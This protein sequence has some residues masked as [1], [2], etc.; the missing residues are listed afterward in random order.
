[1]IFYLGTHEPAWLTRTTV[2]LFVSR[3]RLARRKSLPRAVGRWALDSGGFTEL[4]MYGKWQTEPGRYAD[5][6]QA[7]RESIGGLDFAAVQDWMCEPFMLARTGKTVAEHQALTIASYLDLLALAPSVP[8]CPVLQ[9]Y[10]IDEYLHHVEQY[11][12]AGINLA[13][14]PRVGVGSVCR[15]Q[16]SFEAVE[17]F[18]ALRPVGA[19]LHGFGLKGGFIKRCF[20]HGLASCDSLAWSY[21]AR[22]RGSPLDGCTHKSCA[23]CLR[24][25]MMWRESTIS[26]VRHGSQ[27]LL[28]I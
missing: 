9:G 2:P 26:F 7:W 18:A 17:L 14:L 6:A 20:G 24:F 25:A 21:R 12:A 15:R 4:A 16:A 11:Q 19:N 8:W 23:N 3:R 28:P 27:A 10:K 1:V 22:R 13:A 5:E